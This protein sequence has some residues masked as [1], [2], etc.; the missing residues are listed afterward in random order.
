MSSRAEASPGQVGDREGGIFRKPLGREQN[1]T[2]P[3]SCRG[4]GYLGAWPLLAAQCSCFRGRRMSR[5]EERTSEAGKRIRWKIRCEK[6]FAHRGDCRG[7]FRGPLGWACIGVLG[8]DQA[9]VVSG[10]HGLPSQC[11]AVRGALGAVADVPR[12]ESV[13]AMRLRDR[14]VGPA[15]QPSAGA[16]GLSPSTYRRPGPV[17]KHRTFF[18]SRTCLSLRHLFI[19][20]P[21]M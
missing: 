5:G 17:S 14:V 2:F 4:P 6:H 1:T 20:S 19:T 18:S 16:G 21:D 15:G 3:S 11:R 8:T 7:C 13:P 9:N 12:E 10:P